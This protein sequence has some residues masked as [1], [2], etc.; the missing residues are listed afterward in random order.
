[1]ALPPRVLS[2]VAVTWNYSVLL[3]RRA[4]FYERARRN[5]GETG[6]VHRERFALGALCV[7]S[8]PGDA[9]RYFSACFDLTFD[10]E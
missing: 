1:M 2:W 7:E 10:T 5:G 6:H 4:V 9:G 8:S 3:F